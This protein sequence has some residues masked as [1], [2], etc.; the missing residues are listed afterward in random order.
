MIQA[1]GARL[2]YL[3]PYSPDLNPI[4]QAFQDQTLDAASSEA[5]RRG[6]LAP[7]R[8]PRPGHPASR[9]RQLLRQCGLCFSQK[10]KRSNRALSLSSVLKRSRGPS[11]V[12]VGLQELSA[13]SASRRSKSSTALKTTR[14]LSCHNSG[15]VHDDPIIRTDTN[16]TTGNG[17]PSRDDPRRTFA[18]A[19]R[20]CST[21]NRQ[22]E[23]CDFLDI[24][25]PTIHHSA[26][27]NVRVSAASQ[28]FEKISD[29]RVLTATIS[30]CLRSCLSID[31][32]A[33]AAI[34]GR[35]T[36]AAGPCG[37]L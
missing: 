4:E 24:P 2:W 11:E 15:V 8:S 18:S 5:H 17:L 26:S 21:C 29:F 37:F 32:P 13:K 36:V 1:A 33:A 35:Q 16:S 20:N 25:A 14:T 34:G 28:I 12:A 27:R 7:H 30:A 6:H 22:P 9:M 31:T 10:V 23:A 19:G 3:P